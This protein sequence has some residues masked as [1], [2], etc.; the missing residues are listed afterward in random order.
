MAFPINAPERTFPKATRDSLDSIGRWVRGKITVFFDL[1][2][3]LYLAFKELVAERKKGFSLVFEITLRQI[4]FT[5]VQALKVVTVI[6]LALGT[7]V[8]VQI[9]TQLSFLGGGIEFIVPILVLVLFR[10]LGPL[11]TAI[12]VV[13]R[14]GTAIATELGNLVIAHE[15]EA[16]QVMGINPVYFIVTPRILGVTLAVIC[17]TA[18]FITVGLL[19][20]FGVSKLILPITFPSFLRE[21]E[22]ALTPND[23]LFGFLKSLIFGLLIALT[24]TYYGLGVRHSLIEVPQAATRGVVSAMLFCFATNALLTV[25]FYL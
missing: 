20:G 21:L 23:L 2:T 6:A 12:I 10:E 13:G 16:I 17:L 11:L 22:V 15:L 3:L 19:G 9:G 25:L 7:V 18:I 8:I 14:S 5:G 4:Y 1:S 24:C